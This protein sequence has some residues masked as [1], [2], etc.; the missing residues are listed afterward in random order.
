M[1]NKAV[2]TISFEQSAPHE[3]YE[4]FTLPDYMPE[5]RKI[6]LCSAEILPD[7]KFI[8]ENGITVSGLV[9]YNVLYI[10]DNSALSNASLSSEYTFT[11]P[12]R[13]E[14][15]VSA[16]SLCCKTYIES[17]GCRASA[18][19]ALRISSKLKSHF[20]C[21]A[22]LYPEE[23]LT[24]TGID[25][26]EK[27]TTA[28]EAALEKRQI[29]LHSTDIKFIDSSGSASGE[30]RIPD[31]AVIISCKGKCAVFDTQIDGDSVVLRGDAYLDCLVLDTEG[32]YVLIKSK[33]PID[34]HVS[35]D[36]GR[37][38]HTGNA[39]GSA[40]AR[41]A[42]VNLNNTGS[43][44]YS[45]NMEFDIDIAVG[46]N[47]SCDITDDAYSTLC[48]GEVSYTSCNVLSA[49]HTKGVRLSLNSSKEIH[50]DGMNVVCV[51]GRVMTESI[52]GGTDDSLNLNGTCIISVVLA[53]NG[54][55][56]C[57]DIQIPFHIAPDCKKRPCCALHMICEAQ[58]VTADAHIDGNKLFV[59]AE[60]AASPLLFESFAESYVSSISLDHT[61]STKKSG[62]KIRICYP[63]ENESTWDIGKRYSCPENRIIPVGSGHSP[64]MILPHG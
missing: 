30:I 4:E 3:T 49:L 24:A 57:E 13:R 7:S 48:R 10:G 45:W 19:R 28:D 12:L 46:E 47:I 41:F 58:V 18:P 8:D 27:V 15:T 29:T 60:L 20:F 17:T 52:E 22:K 23:K 62:M 55:A 21:S 1:E 14:N 33:A 6:V 16:D 26:T 31:G 53:G 35:I 61:E 40:F 50:G 56:V 9:M 25:G 34:E 59:S 37:N 39:Y 42:S 44:V 64:V 5:V 54:D 43:N 51:S 2:S 38:F 32:K 63:S 11:M 36:G